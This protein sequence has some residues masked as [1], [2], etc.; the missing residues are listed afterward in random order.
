M[1]WNWVKK[2]KGD[3]PEFW[4]EYV[5]SFDFSSKERKIIVVIDFK[6]IKDI[7]NNPESLSIGCL[8]IENNFLVVKTFIELIFQKDIYSIPNNELETNEIPVFLNFIKNA[9]LIGLNMNLTLEIINNILDKSNLGSLKNQYIDIG[10]MH[11]KLIENTS[12]DLLSLNELCEIYKIQNNEK[13]TI[14]GDAFMTALLFLKLKK[15]LEI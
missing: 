2:F 7:L 9:T 13:R 1:N 14:S 4:N 10:L 8:E 5:T 12:E 3:N 15:K 11:H 6:Y